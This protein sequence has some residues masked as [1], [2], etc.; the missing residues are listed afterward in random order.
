MFLTIGLS[1]V[2]VKFLLNLEMALKQMEMSFLM[3]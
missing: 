3:S 1:V 2:A